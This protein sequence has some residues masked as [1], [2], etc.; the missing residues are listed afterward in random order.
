MAQQFYQKGKFYTLPIIEI[1][2][3]GTNSFFIVDANGREYAIK[4][5]DFQKTDSD[6]NQL[7]TSSSCHPKVFVKEFCY[8]L[9]S[10]HQHCLGVNLLVQR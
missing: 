8:F 7:L 3:E 9:M 1:R 6:V 5:F 10:C 4:M 2:N